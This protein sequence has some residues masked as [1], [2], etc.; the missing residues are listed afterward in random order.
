MTRAQIRVGRRMAYATKIPGGIEAVELIPEP[1]PLLRTEGQRRKF[2]AQPD[3]VR[4]NVQRSMRG[5]TLTVCQHLND[6]RTRRGLGSKEDVGEMGCTA[7][8]WKP[9]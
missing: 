2:K 8:G 3:N 1:Y 9:D 5:K 7:T 6:G 4:S